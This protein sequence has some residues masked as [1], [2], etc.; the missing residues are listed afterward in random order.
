MVWTVSY[1]LAS[2]CL[3]LRNSDI[4]AWLG[5]LPGHVYANVRQPLVH[6]LNLAH[7]MPLSAVW[8][9]PARNAHLDGPPLLHAKTGGST[10][11]PI[12]ENIEA[13]RAGCQSLT[14]AIDKTIPADRMMMQMVGSFAKF[15]REMI[16]QQTCAGLESARREGRIGGRR[17]KLTVRRRTEVI[18]MVSSDRKTTAETTRLFGVHP[19]TMSRLL[20]TTS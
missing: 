9:G 6:I 19:A 20:N 15:E 11:L 7:L 13:K 18:E 14:E 4:E 2:R 5:S 16:R 17:P 8:A 12:I 10:P 1:L 3:P